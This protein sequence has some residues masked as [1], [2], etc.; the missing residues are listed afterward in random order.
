MPLFAVEADGLDI[1]RSFSN[2]FLDIS[3][4]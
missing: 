4:L 3:W 2:I 1:F